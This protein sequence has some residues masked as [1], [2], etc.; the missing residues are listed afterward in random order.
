MASRNTQLPLTP[1]SDIYAIAQAAAINRYGDSLVW[2]DKRVKKAAANGSYE[3]TFRM[4][5][6]ENLTCSNNADY[7]GFLATVACCG[8]NVVARNG[9]DLAVVL[10]AE[11]SVTIDC[12]PKK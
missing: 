7:R 3:V 10:S 4:A 8:Y 6:V 5:D 2:V 9:A 11:T 1:A 12:F